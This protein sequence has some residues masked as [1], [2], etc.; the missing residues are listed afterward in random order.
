MAA[1]RQQGSYLSI[2]LCAFTGFVAGLVLWTGG[3]TAIG[4]I[5]TLASFCLLVYSLFALRGIKHLE[6][7]E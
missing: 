5:V 2:F 7:M 4:V 6:F 3:H 1:N